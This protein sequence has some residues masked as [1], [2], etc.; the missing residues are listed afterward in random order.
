MSINQY[1]EDSYEQTLIS[2][3]KQMGYQYECGY[4]VER[5]YRNPYYDSDLR[6]ALHRLN[7]M[8]MSGELK[9]DDVTLQKRTR[10]VYTTIY[11]KC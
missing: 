8:L 4:D 6:E 7:P 11:S 3:F 10:Y 2:L 1:N 9:V 5:D